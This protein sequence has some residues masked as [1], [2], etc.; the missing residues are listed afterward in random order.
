MFSLEAPI[1]SASHLIRGIEDAHS[2]GHSYTLAA[3]FL[4]CKIV[5]LCSC[6]CASERV[7]C[8][9]A[10]CLC[11]SGGYLVS[12]TIA[13]CIFCGLFSYPESATVDSFDCTGFPNRTS[14]FDTNK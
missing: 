10:V 13:F 14:I 8:V 2:H 9:V 1:H 5:R 12:F 6:V 7:C 11:F 4:R 3:T